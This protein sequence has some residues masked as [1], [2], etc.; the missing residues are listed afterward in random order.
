MAKVIR[1]KGDVS[2]KELKS[3]VLELDRLSVFVGWL[4]S[5]VYDDSTPVAGVAAVQEYGAP[6]RGIPP[7]PFLRPTE[8]E[9]MKDWKAI[10]EWGAKA[11][12]KG[13]M[14]AKDVMNVLGSKM[15]G[16][17]KGA[18]TDISGPELSPI[19]IALRKIRNDDKYKIGGKLVGAV[20]GAIADGKTG[21]GELGDQSFGNKDILRETG[22]MI[23]TLT[24]EVRE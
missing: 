19:T 21:P 6:S 2:I 13:T 4:E 17:I 23:A 5:A 3:R 22:Y 16:D 9:K 12:L 7:R 24:H 20:A 18:I 15:V 10:I 11:I 1:K 8:D 14:T